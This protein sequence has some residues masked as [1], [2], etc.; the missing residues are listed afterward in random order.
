MSLLGADVDLTRPEEV[1]HHIARSIE[2]GRPFVVANHNSHSLY[3]LRRDPEFARF[4]AEA[5][6][7]EIDSTPLIFFARLL[8]LRS[9]P[10]HRC[11]YLD[12]RDHFWSLADRRGWRIFYLGAEPG[13]AARA[14][15]R[16]SGRY[17]GARIATRDGYFDMALGSPANQA[18]VDEIA[19]FRPDV[20]FVGMGM[21]RQE[22][23]ITRNRAALPPCVVLSVGA[24]FD[25]EAGVQRAA[26]RWT[27]RIGLEWAFRL[28]ANPRRM[29]TR[30]C[31]EPWTLAPAALADLRAAWLRRGR[32]PGAPEGSASRLASGG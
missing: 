19:A 10:F 15:E 6:L 4:Y 2:E 8:G 22:I 9:R 27:G 25:Y 31:V 3:L 11:T 29:F 16:L 7:T 32:R 21:P 5:D 12:W 13:V 17:P 26:P 18:V 1:L 24:A 14:A 30:Y 28:A 20:L 23:W